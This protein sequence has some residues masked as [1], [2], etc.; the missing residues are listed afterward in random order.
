MKL[1][2]FARRILTLKEELLEKEVYVVAE[3]GLLFEPAVKYKTKEP[4]IW[5]GLTKENVEYAVISYE[6]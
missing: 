5:A 6:G 3:N 1:K 4:V 2:D